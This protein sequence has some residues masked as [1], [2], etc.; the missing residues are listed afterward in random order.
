MGTWDI[1]P[2]DNDT[3]ADFAIALDEAEPEG[4]LNLIRNVLVRTADATGYL[5]EAQEAVA[6]A[7][8][9]AAQCPGAE[10]L[11]S[12][13]E[14]EKPLPDFPATLRV[15]GAEAL[16]RILDDASEGDSWVDPAVERRWRM[17]L[18]RLVSVLDPPPP[19]IP[20]FDVGP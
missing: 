6:A 7:A 4:R 14:P 9:I 5:Q 10:P 19:T 18:S 20:L 16:R 11:D 15:L 8:L 3:A 1:G 13:H 2:F 12:V 17:S